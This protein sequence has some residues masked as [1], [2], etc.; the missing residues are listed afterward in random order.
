MRYCGT[1]YGTND[2]KEPLDETRIW[3]GIKVEV[4]NSNAQEAGARRARREMLH[5]ED[6]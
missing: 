2:R 4:F 3:R 5:E 6:E 1:A